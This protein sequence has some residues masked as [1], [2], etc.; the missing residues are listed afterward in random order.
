MTKRS[1]I[2]EAEQNVLNQAK[3]KET[4]KREQTAH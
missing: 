2:K 4:S 3:F 1:D